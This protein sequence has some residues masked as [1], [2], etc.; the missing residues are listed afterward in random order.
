MPTLAII[1]IVL[2]A[3]GILL[4]FGPFLA[5]LAQ[6]VFVFFLFFLFFK[7]VALFSKMF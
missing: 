7:F 4:T 1:Y 5:F 3:I 2:V 6:A